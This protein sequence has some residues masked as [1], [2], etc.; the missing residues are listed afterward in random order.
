[1]AECILRATS[2]TPTHGLGIRAAAPSRRSSSFQGEAVQVAPRPGTSTLKIKSRPVTECSSTGSGVLGKLGRM[3]QQKVKSDYDRI[4]KGVTKTRE[5]LAVVDEL[6][7]YYTM[8][9]KE[10]ILE[11]LEEALLLSDFG[12]STSFKVVD[13]LRDTIIAKKL[14]TG[15]EIK[16]ALKDQISKILN[17]KGMNFDLT[18]ATS[19]PSVYMIVGVNGGGKTTTIGKLANMLSRREEGEGSNAQGEAKVMLASGDTFRAAA[20]EQLEKWAERSGA[21]FFDVKDSRPATVLFNAVQAAE[22]DGYEYVICDTSGRLHTN[23]DLMEELAKCKRSI[24]K[25]SKNGAPHEVLL[26]IDATTGLNMVNQAREFNDKVGL[27]GIILT[28]LDGSSRGGCV[29]SVVDELSIPVKFVG[30]G[31]GIKDLQ[32]FNVEAFVD[33]LFP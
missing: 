15:P 32:P 14:K 6:L 31:E 2:S 5:K 27:T 10:S 25:G 12:P 8:D 20:G 19:Q 23:F 22:K 16:A 1:M 18:V 13:N 28:K 17:K 21:T 3:F 7:G 26:V 11:E 33:A 24:V 29:V 4:F 9:E 30:V